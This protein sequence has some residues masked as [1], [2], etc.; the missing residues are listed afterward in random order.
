MVP[1]AA[2]R[3]PGKSGSC[4]SSRWPTM[5]SGRG[6]SPRHFNPQPATGACFQSETPAD[7]PGL[8]ETRLATAKSAGRARKWSG[9]TFVN[10][11]ADGCGESDPPVGNNEQTPRGEVGTRFPA[12]SAFLRTELRSLP[13]LTRLTPTTPS[14]PPAAAEFARSSW[15]SAYC[16]VLR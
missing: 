12:S 14:R 1:P 8:A 16:V 7:K 10:G 13:Y 2:V 5:P 11:G 15:N 6:A 9:T 3:L 4:S